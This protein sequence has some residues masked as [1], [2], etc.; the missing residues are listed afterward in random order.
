MPPSLSPGR[1]T[2]IV[3]GCR[4][5]FIKAWTHFNRLGAV[6]LGKIA[7]TELLARS[8]I[9]A[10]HIDQMIF[11][12]VVQA[13]K[14][15]NIAREIALGCGIPPRVP[16]YTVSLACISSLVAIANGVD[17]IAAGLADVIVA[18]GAESLSDVP[19]TF[20]K[21]ARDLFLE[22]NRGRNFRQKLSTGLKFKFRD[23]I[24]DAPALEEPSTGLTMGQSAEQMAQ[25]N[26]IS[27]QEQ[28]EF[29]LLSHIRASAAQHKGILRSE[30]SPAFLV[31]EKKV[32]QEDNVIRHDA[33][34]ESMAGLEPVF[35]R[36]YGTI[37]AANASPLTD[38]AAAVMLVSEEKA[39]SLG[40]KPLA[41][42]RS[43]AF[44]AHSPK[45]QMLMG[46]AY[47]TP[48]ALD[49]AG[50]K[51]DDLSAI[52]MHEAFAASVLSTIKMF[53]SR[54]WAEEKLNRSEP[55]GE[56]DYEKLNRYGG[57]I[58]I[59]HP[60]AATGARMVTTLA[61]ELVRTQSEFGLVT[62]CAA[63]GHGGAMVLEHNNI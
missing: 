16:A 26:G 44:S 31:E 63:G 7:V 24:P 22:L 56:V 13:L 41:F 52:E 39:Q 51:W 33:S 14:M 18:G 55:I 20:G 36:R 58:A 30:I 32:V 42:V 46:P 1:R 8:G 5:P 3:A 61:N 37:T 48:V 45:D 11:G 40:V 21:R 54:K 38:G 17:Q 35:D 57:S 15:P 10:P 25:L 2:A 9:D 43:Y 19:L 27:R 4:T 62:A 29:A 50:I 47:A 59:G 60:F 12:V 28:D 6:D 49:R 34:L 53:E 23:F